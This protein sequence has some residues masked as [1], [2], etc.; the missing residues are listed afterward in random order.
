VLSTWL[1]LNN[2]SGKT[3]DQHTMNPYAVA[4]FECAGLYWEKKDD[5]VCK[6]RYKEVGNPRLVFGSRAHLNFDAGWTPWER[7]W[8][9]QLHTPFYAS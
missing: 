5:G 7:F 2:A 9:F 8:P 3:P 1:A 4:T 6:I